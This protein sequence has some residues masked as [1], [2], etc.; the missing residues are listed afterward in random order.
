M[1]E[2]APSCTEVIARAVSTTTAQP[3]YDVWIDDV[4]VD[5]HAVGCDR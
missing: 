4:I 5:D 2:D 3:I 1:A